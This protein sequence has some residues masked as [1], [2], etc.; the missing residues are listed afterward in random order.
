MSWTT[1]VA[2]LSGGS[3]LS[4]TP[5]SGTST[6]GSLQI[7]LVNVYANAS[8]LKA[9]SYS[10]QIRVRAAGADNSPQVVTVILNILPLGSN[11]NAT[12]RPTGLIFAARAGGA[13]PH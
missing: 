9:G 11:P 4:A 5:L 12:V 10:G 2:T 7:P 3:W 1:E 8:G 13:S 6:A